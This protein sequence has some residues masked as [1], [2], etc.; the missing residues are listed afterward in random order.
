ML[1]AVHVRRALIPHHLGP[2]TAAMSIANLRY[3]VTVHLPAEYVNLIDQALGPSQSLSR[4]GYRGR[5]DVVRHAVY[6]FLVE[7]GIQPTLVPEM[8]DAPKSRR[9]AGSMSETEFWKMLTQRR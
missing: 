1:I 9:R 7:N 6:K 4:K 8:V 2:R 3:P 5:A